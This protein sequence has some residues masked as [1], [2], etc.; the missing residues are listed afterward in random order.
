MRPKVLLIED[1][2]S[3]SASLRKVL[4]AEG[5]EVDVASRGD[6][7][8]AQARQ[9]EYNVVVTDLRLPGLGG[10]DL[11]AQLHAAKPK[12]PIILMTAHGTTETAIG[13]TKLGACDYLLKPFEADELLDLVASAVASSRLMSEPVE[14]GEARLDRSAIIGNSRAM[15]AIYKEIG[16]VAATTA[17]V[18]IRGAT[19]TGKELIAR[20]IYQHSDRADKPFIAVNCAA[21]PDAL[22]E[23]ELFGHERGAFTGAQ[24]RRIGRFEQAHGGTLFL[25][26]IG[27]LNANTQGKLLRVLQE[28]CIQR[29]GSETNVPVDV[30]VL[31]ATHRDLEN[32]IAEKGFREDLFYRLSVVTIT[33]PPLNERVEDIPQ[34]TKYFI[35][36]YG[37]ELGLDTPSIQTEAISFLQSQPW[38]GNVRELENVIRQALLLAKPFTISLEHVQQVVNRA[39][40]PAAAAQQTHAVYIAELLTRAQNGE[41]HN[42]Y[43]HMIA[44]LEPELFK[45]AIQLAQGNQAKAARW[46][47]VTRLKMR[48]KLTEFGLHPAQENRE[49]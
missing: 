18:L 10:L 34:L 2:D 31:A 17:T 47:G 29:L 16:R 24:S 38:P 40:K 36:R 26:E 12:Q 37:N 14:M 5:Y 3:T 44:D 4:C 19:G 35:Q 42:A 1:D 46:L 20:A 30:R 9:R 13:A 32:A 15:Q 48:E 21:I 25:D 39:R 6:D 22:L 49:K 28:R 23:S 7:G 8:L 27:D 41:L 33:L 11:V 43:A 45:Q